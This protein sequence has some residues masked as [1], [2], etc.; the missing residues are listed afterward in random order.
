MCVYGNRVR[1]G[2]TGR[3][4]YIRTYGS[5]KERRRLNTLYTQTQGGGSVEVGGDGG[6][7]IKLTGF[8][9]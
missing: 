7:D 2:Q 4:S 5:E 8:D 9:K 1:E 6:R 3:L